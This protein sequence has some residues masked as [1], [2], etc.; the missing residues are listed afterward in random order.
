MSEADQVSFERAEFDKPQRPQ[1][2]CGFCQ[3]PISTQY[4]QIADRTACAQCR[5]SLDRGLLASATRS[6]FARALQ[7]G[8]LAAMA[9]SVSWVVISKVTGYHIGFVAIGIGYL[10]GK[11]VRKGAGGFGARRYQYLAMFLTYASIAMASLPALVEALASKQS[12]SAAPPS[13]SALGSL[14]GWLIVC[15]FAFASPFLNGVRSIMSL[16]IIG[17][18]LLQAWKLTSPAA[19]NVLGPFSVDG[20]PRA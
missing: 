11:A 1:L 3:R 5:A 12:S 9:G 8:I 16:F 15:A 10:V 7:Y 2:A 6:A 19:F 14:L 18:G 13:H 4:W 17:I 20:S